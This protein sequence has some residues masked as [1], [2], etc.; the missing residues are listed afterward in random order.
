[1]A[2][3]NHS[4]QKQCGE[5]RTHLTNTSR[6]QSMEDFTG[7]KSSQKLKAEIIEECCLLAGSSEFMVN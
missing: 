3:I 1:V 2:L 7:W 4:D 5:E 6:S